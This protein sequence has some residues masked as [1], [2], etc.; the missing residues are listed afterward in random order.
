[1]ARPQL[2]I[3]H[4]YFDSLDEQRAYWLGFIFADGCVGDS[5]NGKWAP[6]IS[7]GLSIKDEAHLLKL[8]QAL[9]SEHRIGHRM[10]GEH[11]AVYLAFASWPL[12]R[13]LI[14]YGAVPRKSMVAIPPKL[15][16]QLEPHFWRGY[17]DGNGNIYVPSDG[18]RA[19]LSVVGSRPTCEAFAAW[20]AGV[21]G[22]SVGSRASRNIWTSV[23]GG[24][25]SVAML[26]RALY[27]DATVWL[28]RKRE[29]CESVIA[30]SDNRG[31]RM[32]RIGFKWRGAA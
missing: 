20:A 24:Y 2:P 28:P 14:G 13:A 1:M 26:A 32:R 17:F 11:G 21:L 6:I 9:R 27:R 4:T 31:A 19:S 25:P 23:V 7:I 29:L 12:Q 5:V 10:V 16:A 15:T 30:E 18:R 22:R 3:D 8:R